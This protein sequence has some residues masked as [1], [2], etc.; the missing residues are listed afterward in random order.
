[1][2]QIDCIVGG[3]LEQILE[4]LRLVLL[5]LIV[6]G[7]SKLVPIGPLLLIRSAEHLTYLDN[8]ILLS[9][10]WEEWVAANELSHDSTEC[11]N[12]DWF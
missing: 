3:L 10:P 6:E 7:L 1:L 11:K 5:E 9:F 12:I 4:A 2:Q 8:L